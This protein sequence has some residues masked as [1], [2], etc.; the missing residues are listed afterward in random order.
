MFNFGKDNITLLKE[1]IAY[2][3]NGGVDMGAARRFAQAGEWGLAFREVYFASNADDG[4]LYRQHQASI[5]RLNNLLASNHYY[6]EH[7][8]FPL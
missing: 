5:E 7:L 8:G 3:E 2:L 4:V 6:A 1:L